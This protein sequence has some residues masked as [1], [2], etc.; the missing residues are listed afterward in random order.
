MA[1]GEIILLSGYTLILLALSFYG[2]HRYYMTVLYRRYRKQAPA[3]P[4]SFE[5]ARKPFVTIQLP[6]FNERYVVRRLIDHVC[7]LRYPRELLEIQVLDDSTDDTVEISRAAVEEWRAR[8]VNITLI[9][10]TDRTGFKAG[11]LQNG[12][13]QAQGEL[14]A[15]FDA[16][17]TPGPDFLERTVPYFMDEGVG[18]VQAR[19]THINRRYSLLTRAQ[20]VLLDG[21]FVIEHTARNR[22]GRFFNFNGTAGIWRQKTIDEAGGWQHDTLTEDL[23]L[24][25]RAQ[26]AGWHFVY[27]NDLLA[28][29]ELPIEMNAF[30]TQQHRWAKGSIQVG[31]KLLP[32]ILR[33]DLPWRIKLEAFVHLTNNVGYVL[34]VLMSILLPFTLQIRVEQGW[35]KAILL[36]LPIFFGAT[37]TVSLFYLH[38]QKEAGVMS[39]TERL[40]Y[41]PIVLALGIGLAVNNTR[42]TLEALF[43]H[44]S[45]F[46]RTPKLAVGEAKG[47]SERPRP[48]RIYM[49]GRNLLSWFEISLGAVYT[50]T[51]IYCIQNKIWMAV[52]FMLI[53]QFG[54]LY[55]GLMSLFQWSSLRRTRLVTEQDAT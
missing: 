8:G 6:V 41:L 16:D 50:Y 43:G 17:F 1:P 10:R 7:A 30:K 22:S 3:P 55:T 52:P 14:I 51:L 36:D 26:L 32:R 38:S 40:L 18:M 39:R 29:A 48:K 37:V 27:L 45:P 54:F 28:P 24:S 35:Y 49:S 15:V 34:M 13:L 2:T 31:M 20:S 9:H 47:K 4:V 23:D 21:H 19:W 11:A 33:S 12:M 5:T 53:F 25:Y 46:V 44:E 42:A